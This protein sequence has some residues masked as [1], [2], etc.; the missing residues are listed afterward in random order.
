MIKEIK[1]YNKRSKPDWLKVKI[2]FN[3]NSR[4]VNELVRTHSLNT[5]C[6]EARGPNIYECWDAKTATI[7]ILGEICTRSCGFCSVKTG[8]PNVLDWDEPS[9]VAQAVQKMDLEHIVITSVDRDDIKNDYGASIWAETI[10][11]I[12]ELNPTVM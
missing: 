7:M 12:K 6:E 5:V 1:K 10:F 11:A 4:K 2:K 8:K 9:R 3:D